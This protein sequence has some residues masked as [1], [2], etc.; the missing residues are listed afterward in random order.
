[1]PPRECTNSAVS[2][3]AKRFNR[4][5]CTNWDLETYHDVPLTHLELDEIRY[6]STEEVGPQNS[7]SG[8][9]QFIPSYSITRFYGACDRYYHASFIAIFTSRNA[10]VFQPKAIRYSGRSFSAELLPSDW[11]TALLRVALGDR[12]SESIPRKHRCRFLRTR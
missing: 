10:C 11:S 4:V 1:M 9:I 6:A 3:I 5:A 12:R 7:S 2:L 8:K